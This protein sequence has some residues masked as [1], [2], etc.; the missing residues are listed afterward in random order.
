MSFRINETNPYL[1]KKD[2]QMQQAAEKLLQGQSVVYDFS[3]LNKNDKET[4][5]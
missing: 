3:F 2:L 4:L 1:I 5:K